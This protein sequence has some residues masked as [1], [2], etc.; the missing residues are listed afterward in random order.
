VQ[1]EQGRQRQKGINKEDWGDGF[2]KNFLSDIQFPVKGRRSNSSAKE[3]VDFTCT[4]GK[5]ARASDREARFSCQLS[6]LSPKGS[7][8]WSDKLFEAN[9][10]AE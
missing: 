7:A 3:A 10:L 5:L 1:F 4:I 8:N 6:Q 9:L 2:W